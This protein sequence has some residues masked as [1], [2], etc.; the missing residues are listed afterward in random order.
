MDKSSNFDIIKTYYEGGQWD[1]NRVNNVVGKKLGIT[2]AEYQEI[3][4]LAYPDKE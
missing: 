3:T 1:I 4:G 2:E